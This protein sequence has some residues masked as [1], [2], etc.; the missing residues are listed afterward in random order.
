MPRS[1]VTPHKGGSADTFIRSRNDRIRY[2]NP[3]RLACK[4]GKGMF[5]NNC[6][7]GLHGPLEVGRPA[8]SCQRNCTHPHSSPPDMILG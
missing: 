1:L 7:F 8:S 4:E 6:K 2:R 3:Q 5:F